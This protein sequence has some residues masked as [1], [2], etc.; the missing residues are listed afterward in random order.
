MPLI[1]SHQFIP[2]D[3]IAIAEAINQ[4]EAELN[5]DES[6]HR[7]SIFDAEGVDVDMNE[8]DAS[9]Q[10]IAPEERHFDSQSKYEKV[11]AEGKEA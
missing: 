5:E 9:L 11:S 6:A 1:F 7:T 2:L 8:I 4:I 3:D 10:Q